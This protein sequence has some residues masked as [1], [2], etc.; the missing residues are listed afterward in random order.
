MFNM[1]LLKAYMAGVALP[2]IICPFIFMTLI[3]MG[4][5]NIVE[6]MPIYFVPLLWGV[7]N[8]FSVGMG[9]HCPIKDINTRY[10]IHGAV[11]GVI[12]S[13]LGLFVFNVDMAL[14]GMGGSFGYYLIIG[15]AIIYAL[16]WRYIVLY[17]NKTLGL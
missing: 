16:V 4:K 10:L 8:M 7:W 3:S 14:F 12:L 17:F 11:L 2:V 9:D 13:I 15:A 1:K 6:H 5:L